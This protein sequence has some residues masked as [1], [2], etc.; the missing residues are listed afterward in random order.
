MAIRALI[1]QAETL[2]L[3]S[4]GRYEVIANPLPA[5]A[6]VVRVDHGMLPGYGVT[7]HNHDGFTVILLIESAEFKKEDRRV[8]LE[9]PVITKAEVLMTGF[10]G[11]HRCINCGQLK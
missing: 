5:D 4:S 6:K 1:I 2:L 9:S 8:P 3:L 11:K 10:T 7:H